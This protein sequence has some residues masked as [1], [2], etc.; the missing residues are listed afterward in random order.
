MFIKRFASSSLFLKVLEHFSIQIFAGLQK[1]FRIYLP[2][3]SVIKSKLPK[4]NL[5]NK[6]ISS[7]SKDCSFLK[8]S[9]VIRMWYPPMV[10]GNWFVSKVLI[11]F[12]TFSSLR[13][14]KFQVARL[15]FYLWQATNLLMWLC[16]IVNNIIDSAII[17]SIKKQKKNH[18]LRRFFK[19][20]SEYTQPWEV[21]IKI[22]RKQLCRNKNTNKDRYKKKIVTN[23]LIQLWGMEFTNLETFK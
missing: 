4:S 11:L 22:G 10:Q 7:S 1:L 23:S 21:P 2:T 3:F 20:A 14:L 18:F 6:F 12:I 9:I 16:W 15:N 5:F 17:T 8:Y 19:F 13:M